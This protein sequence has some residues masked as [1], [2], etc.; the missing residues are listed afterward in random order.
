MFSVTTTVTRLASEKQKPRVVA[1][2]MRG[3][4]PPRPPTDTLK[5]SRS[6]RYGNRRWRVQAVRNDSP[7]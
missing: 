5:K 2:R 6:V 7:R 1:V 4:E 3:L